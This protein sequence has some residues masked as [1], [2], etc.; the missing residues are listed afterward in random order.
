[1]R[2]GE[3]I[4]QPWFCN[5]PE[6]IKKSFLLSFNKTRQANKATV[7]VSCISGS[8]FFVYKELKDNKTCQ[9]YLLQAREQFIWK[10]GTP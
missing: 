4:W 7:M 1:M 8:F 3:V 6:C 9:D 2:Q 5:L 10:N